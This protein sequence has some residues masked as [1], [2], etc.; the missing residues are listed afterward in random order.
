MAATGSNRAC[1]TWQANLP[2]S[3]GGSRRGTRRR[4]ESRARPAGA[5]ES[6][7][8]TAVGQPKRGPNRRWQLSLVG[9]DRIGIVREVS[10]VLAQYDVNVEKLTTHT[11]P[12]AMSAEIMF[13][14]HAE[15]EADA[16]LDQPHCAR[17]G[18]AVG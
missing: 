10:Q 7:G 2:A 17:S 9:H 16:G 1:R 12:A 14:A 15:L 3:C 4:A 8:E 11:A 5:V 13:H 18:A 6:D